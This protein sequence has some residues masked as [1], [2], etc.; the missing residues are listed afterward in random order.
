[1]SR[2]L[3]VPS[4]RVDPGV[5]SSGSRNGW[6]NA[7]ASVG[8]IGTT[9]SKTVSD[10]TIDT[11]GKIDPTVVCLTS[12]GTSFVIHVARRR[13]LDAPGPARLH[14]HRHDHAP[15]RTVRVALEV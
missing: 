5:S 13:D 12:T 11:I 10:A 6:W 3:G 1:M 2:V 15:A 4:G 9:G 14:E 7:D 8:E